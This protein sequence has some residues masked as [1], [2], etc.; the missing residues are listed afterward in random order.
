MN[1]KPNTPSNRRHA[2]G[3]KQERPPNP[4]PQAVSAA[5]KPA[6]PETG[7]KRAETERGKKHW[8]EYATAIFAL[9]A[10]IGGI[11]AA[12]FSGYQGW[13]ARDT[14]KRQLRAY[15]VVN[16][17]GA[18]ITKELVLRVDVEIKNSGQTPAYDGEART[19]IVPIQSGDPEPPLAVENVQADT[20]IIGA[21]GSVTA[22]PEMPI[23]A[24]VIPAYQKL[25]RIIYVVG[26]V[27]Y[28]DIFGCRRYLI[29]KYRGKR[30][31]GAHWI[32]EP[33]PDA[34]HAN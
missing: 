19:R 10:A 25:D 18:I 1:T 11:A 4:P 13:V 21:G 7:D 12:T 16:T 34:E 22:E 3:H 20:F 30:F 31:D 14:E 9:I 27:T 15:V 26:K 33:V 5:G 17:A 2:P 28:S 24:D 23:T 32:M 29:F 8:L 6:H